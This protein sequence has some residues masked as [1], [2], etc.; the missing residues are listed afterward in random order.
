[1]TAIVA[2]RKGRRLAIA[3]DSL[4]TFG[5]KHMTGQNHRSIKIRKVGD[6]YVAL[7]G[8]TLYK[9]ILDDYLKDRKTVRLKNKE[10]IYRF[11]LKFW[12]E[13]KENYS[14]VNNQSGSKYNPFA[15]LSSSFMVLNKNGIFSVDSSMSVT[16]F[17][18]YYAIG[19]G[20]NYCLGALHAL[21]NTDLNAK[22][23]ARGAIAASIAFDPYCGGK[24]RVREIKRKK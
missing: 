18:Q 13:L 9:N 4:T 2:V 17:K 16:Q 12:K 15:E 7:S 11:M 21:Y 22:E 3:S 20:A 23:I 6:S 14:F 24:I 5:S 10:E 8:Y 1:M 19:S